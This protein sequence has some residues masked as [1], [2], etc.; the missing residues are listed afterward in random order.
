MRFQI[1][2][3]ESLVKIWSI[4]F[5]YLELKSWDFVSETR[6]WFCLVAVLHWLIY[7][8]SLKALAL[9]A[10]HKSSYAADEVSH[11]FDS[12]FVIY[13][14]VMTHSDKKTKKEEKT[15]PMEHIAKHDVQRLY[16]TGSGEWMRRLLEIQPYSF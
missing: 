10:A 12:L 16:Q 13:A 8:E 15:N 11:K 7:V 3:S 1:R 14:V 6:I 4:N 5:Q 2:T 9:A